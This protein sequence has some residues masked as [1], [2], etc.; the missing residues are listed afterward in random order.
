MT[1]E[2]TLPHG[3]K[4]SVIDT[5][6][7]TDD[8]ENLA[9]LDK[10]RIQV[11]LFANRPAVGVA[12][13][14]YYAN[15]TGDLYYDDGTSWLG[16]ADSMTGH[17]T[18]HAS[19]GSD[20]LTHQNLSGAGSNS[21]AQVDTHLSDSTK[22][23]ALLD[24]DDMASDDATK[25][26]S[27]QSVKAYVD[28]FKPVGFRAHRNNVDQTGISGAVKL[29]C[30]TEVYDLQGKYDAV[31]NY[32]W[33]PDQTA[34]IV[35]N[36]Q[37]RWK[38]VEIGKVYEVQIYKNGALFS[39]ADKTAISTANFVMQLTVTDKPNGSSDYYEAYVYANASTSYIQGTI[40]FTYFE[41]F[42]LGGNI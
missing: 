41:G 13:R 31:T 35:L 30:G 22:H 5:D 24:E 3:L 18:S 15:D 34:P 10:H 8:K 14:F 1:V 4:T 37:V 21:H 17:A 36:L 19:G 39:K 12:E 29:Q 28:S 25:A 2:N 7:E 27:Q 16:V 26:A 20:A 9:L 32:R 42:S 40:T 23:F 38:S 33:I 6:Y 11:G